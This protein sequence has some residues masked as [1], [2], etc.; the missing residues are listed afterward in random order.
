MNY[1]AVTLIIA[2]SIEVISILVV[3]VTG[4]EVRSSMSTVPYKPLKITL[5]SRF[6]VMAIIPNTHFLQTVMVNASSSATDIVVV[7]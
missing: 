6:N 3:G 7:T 5:L 2:L 1:R 4:V